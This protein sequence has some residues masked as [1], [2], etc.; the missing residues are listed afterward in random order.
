MEKKWYTGRYRRHLCDM[1]IDGWDEKFLSEFHAESYYENLKAAGINAAMLYFQ[2]HVG[3]TYYPTAVG[4]MHPAFE[5]KPDEMRRLARMC[6]ENGIAVIGYYSLNYN[7]WAHDRHP[8]WRMVE[9]NGQSARMNKDGRYGFCCPNNPEYR[10]FVFTQIKEMLEYFEVDGMFYDMPFWPHVCRCGY[11]RARWEAEAGGEM[12]VVLTGPTGERL[13]ERRRV[14]MGEFAQMVTDCTKALRPGVS[15]EQNFATAISSAGAQV[16]IGDEVN[17]ACDYTGGDLYGGLLAQSFTCKYYLAVSK[18]QPFEYMSSRSPNLSKHTLGKP[19]RELTTEI[20]LT[21]AHHGASLVIDAIDPVGTL[22]GR[23]YRMLGGVFEKERPYERY[24]GEGELLKD[25]GIIY[26]LPSK[27]ERHGQKFTVHHAGLQ[28]SK[29][30]MQHHVPVGVA[31][32]RQMDHLSQYPVLA[33]PLLHSLPEK[34][35]QA[36]IEYVK[37]GGGLYFSGAEQPELVRELLGAEVKGFTEHTMTY[38]APKKEYEELLGNFNEKYPLPFEGGMPLIEGISEDSEVLAR[39]SL[40][41]TTQNHSFFASIHSN[42][43][44]NVTE[45]PAIIRR[46]IGKGRVIWCA[47]PIEKESPEEYERIMMNLLGELGMKPRIRTNASRVVEIVSFEDKERIR[48]SA[49]RLSDEF[50]GK[51][52]AFE[53][54][55]KTERRPA[56]IVLLPDE[57]AVGFE[58]EHGW[59]CFKARELDLFDMYEIRLNN[60]KN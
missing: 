9:E 32:Y 7:T 11:C 44:G 25:V 19:A 14:W 30:L 13:L 12:P 21:C 1:H 58:Y 41:Y 16:S 47:A 38:I 43:P 28:L 8:E 50:E 5:K 26:D 53:V 4:K 29:V 37:N 49:V 54:R 31:T 45:Y 40:P 42:P 60:R 18:N 20:M 22:D 2:S 27:A 59:T 56:E 17:E 51:L 3:Y 35:Q 24:L 34:K 15:V 48:V 33:A 52:P 39:I 36:L 57:T 46:D 6:R 10:E 23:F 55:L